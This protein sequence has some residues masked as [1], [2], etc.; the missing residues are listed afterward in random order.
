MQ[1]HQGDRVLGMILL[2]L[3]PP[4]FHKIL[5]LQNKFLSVRNGFI[6]DLFKVIS[7]YTEQEAFPAHQQPKTKKKKIAYFSLFKILLQTT[8]LYC[9][10]SSQ[11]M[12]RYVFFID[13]MFPFFISKYFTRELY[14]MLKPR[15]ICISAL[16]NTFTFANSMQGS[17]E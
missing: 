6:C 2:E 5:N 8:P 13:N 9:T 10:Y 3:W 15:I 12:F 14:R 16:M 11:S 17:E 7:L 4:K 1:S